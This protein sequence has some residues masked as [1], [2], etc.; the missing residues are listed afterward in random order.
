MLAQLLSVVIPAF[1]EESTI[2]DVISKVQTAA[3]SSS[4]PYEIVVV[5]DGSFDKTGVVAKSHNVRVISNRRNRGKGVALRRGL[6]SA[7]GDIIVTIDADGSHDPKDIGK[8]IRPILDGADVVLGC[9]FFD[10]RGRETTTRLNVFG[11]SI[12]NFAIWLL[13]GKRIKD[14]Q[15]GFRAFRKKILQE[16][17]VSAEGFQVETELTVK[18]LMNGNDVREVPIAITRRIVGNSRVNPLRDGLKIL[19]AMLKAAAVT[20]S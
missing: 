18:M 11:N 17:A 3:G 8:L 16:V 2:G 14:S 1:N 5:D 20:Y 9:R 13:T 6:E 12:I 10:G 4:V 19:M 7:L 15:T